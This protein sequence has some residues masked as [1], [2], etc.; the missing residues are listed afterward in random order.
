MW[1]RKC[2]NNCIQLNIECDPNELTKITTSD[3][4]GIDYK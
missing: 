2:V 1:D 4:M 3:N